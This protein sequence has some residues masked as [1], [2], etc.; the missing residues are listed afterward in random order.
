MMTDDAANRIAKEFA[1]LDSGAVCDVLSKQY[2][3]RTRFMNGI[4]P[5]VGG[6]TMIGRAVTVRFVPWRE[7]LTRLYPD[8]KGLTAEYAAIEAARPGDVLVYDAQ[9]RIGNALLGDIM[10]TRLKVRGGLGFVID[11]AI[12]DGAGLRS[13]GVSVYARD[14]QGTPGPA[15]NLAAELNVPIQCGGV[16]VLPGDLIFADED[17]VVVI[18]QDKVSAVAEAAQAIR[19]REEFVRSKLIGEGVPLDNVYP[20]NAALEKE[21]ASWKQSRRPSGKGAGDR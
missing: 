6:G 15:A 8:T 9:G 12:R 18:P 17:G 21:F 16:L 1:G 20:L 3:M 5:V 19:E 10:A 11:G 14:R 2:G 7:D 13:V 4:R